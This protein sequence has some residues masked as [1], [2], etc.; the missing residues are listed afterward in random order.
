MERA[1]SSIEKSCLEELN[2]QAKFVHLYAAD[3]DPEVL[4]FNSKNSKAKYLFGRVKEL[5]EPQ[6]HDHR[7]GQTV[8][9][10]HATLV[11]MGFVCVSR[12]PNNNKA[13]QNKGCISKG[14]EA[15]GEAFHEG[16]EVI[17]THKPQQDAMKRITAQ[18]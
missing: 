13:K 18:V 1:F 8:L 16:L 14:T 12:S 5:V 15:S 17:D 6:V 2:A 7:T 11:L 3:Y 4:D 9:V 10:P